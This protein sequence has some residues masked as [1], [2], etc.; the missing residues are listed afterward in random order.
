[1]DPYRS[2]QKSNRIRYRQRY[3][4]TPGSNDHN[5]PVWLLEN[6]TLDEI[7]RVL[8]TLLPL[9]TP[10]TMN[11]LGTLTLFSEWEIKFIGEVN[12][13]YEMKHS[14]GFHDRPLSGKQL[15]WL[16]KLYERVAADAESMIIKGSDP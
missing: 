13:L 12:Y 4:E 2:M 7:E 11:A 8:A 16:W 6:T 15:F 10:S 5:D 3:T 1:M 9:A 14:R